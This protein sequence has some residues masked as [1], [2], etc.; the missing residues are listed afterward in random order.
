MLFFLQ[1]LYQSLDFIVTYAFSF[2]LVINGQ[3][4]YVHILFNHRQEISYDPCSTTFAFS[5]ASDAH[6]HFLAPQPR[7][8]PA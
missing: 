1:S 3:Q 8:A 5:F 6:S 4:C 7:S 2:R